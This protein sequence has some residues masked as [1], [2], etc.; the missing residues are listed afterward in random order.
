M[1]YSGKCPHENRN[2]ACRRTYPD[3]T[4]PCPEDYKIE[5]G[6]DEIH[7]A[8]NSQNAKRS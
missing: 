8:E 4:Q 1:C 3:N 5:E 7:I 2:G 6:E